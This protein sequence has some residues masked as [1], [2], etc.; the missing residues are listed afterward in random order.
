MS[1]E[2]QQPQAN[3]PAKKVGTAKTETIIGTSVN[4]LNV[5]LIGIGQAYDLVKELPK[6]SENL[7]AEIADKETKLAELDTQFAEK[8][9]AF[10]IQN[11]LD[12][13]EDRK[14]HVAQYLTDNSLITL[15]MKE[16]DDLV[17]MANH[18]QE[19]TKKAID[20]AVGAALGSAKRSHE[21]ELKIM[22]ATHKTAEADNKA[23]IA[24]LEIQLAAAKAEA[25]RW[26]AAL[27]EERKAGIERA[28]ASAIGSVNVSG[29]T[30]R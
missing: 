7:S 10:Q 19:E 6:M 4:K 8:K 9:R 26:E 2:K 23:K 22:E 5:A 11:E 17:T 20:G 29:P 25:T 14:K 30:G 12:F 24:S 1:K 15:D 13:R 3:T 18:N 27:T 28:K 16:Y 21:S